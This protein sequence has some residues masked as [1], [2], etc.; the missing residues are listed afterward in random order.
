MYS[1]LP[2][3]S[4]FD[5]VVISLP[6]LSMNMG[7]LIASTGQT[8]TQLVSKQ[9]IHFFPMIYDIKISCQTK[10]QILFSFRYS[11]RISLNPKQ[12]KIGR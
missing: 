6:N 4:A 10:K 2:N 11:P 7:P 5:I 9:L 8:A 1:C 12:L 3:K